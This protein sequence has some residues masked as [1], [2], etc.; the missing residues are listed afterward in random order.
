MFEDG[1]AIRALSRDEGV[2]EVFFRFW[3]LIYLSRYLNQE[4]A[5]WP[6]RPSS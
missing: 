2:G 1:G 4:T 5:K 6:F 3:V